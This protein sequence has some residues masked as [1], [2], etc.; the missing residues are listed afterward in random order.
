MKWRVLVVDDEQDIT[1]TIFK[2]GLER[3]GFK[4]DTY[5]DPQKVLREFPPGNYD[6][7]CCWMFGCQE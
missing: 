3:S 6:L 4:V 1:T 5:N 7:F 2:A